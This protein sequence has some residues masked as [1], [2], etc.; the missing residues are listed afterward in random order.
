M[1]IV[2]WTELIFPVKNM[3]SFIQ[4]NCSHSS[5]CP[6]T[7]VLV[8]RSS[9]TISD[10]LRPSQTFAEVRTCT[11]TSVL[12]P[13]SVPVRTRPYSFPEVVSCLAGKCLVWQ[14]RK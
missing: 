5:F 11:D 4:D 12:V 14:L 1:I 7:S 6:D 3:P 10:F 8:P 2:I 13:R 9:Q